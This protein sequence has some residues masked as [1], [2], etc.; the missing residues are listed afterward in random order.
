MW[1]GEAVGIVAAQSIGEPVVRPT[2]VAAVV[3]LPAP[4][5]PPVVV[6]DVVLTVLALLIAATAS[7]GGGSDEP[8]TPPPPGPLQDVDGPYTS[9]DV[10]D[11]AEHLG[12]L[13]SPTLLRTM[14]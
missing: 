9:E 2:D 12:G 7:G 6:A 8:D 4:P 1:V 5:V 14:R 11:V 10:Q 13:I 3:V